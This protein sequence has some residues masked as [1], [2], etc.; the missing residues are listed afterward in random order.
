VTEKIVGIARRAMPWVSLAVGIAGAVL[1]DRGPERAAVVASAAVV[2]WV[3]VLL[4]IWLHR[5][6]QGESLPRPRLVRGVHFSSLVLTQSSIYLQLF[7]ALPFYGKAW[8]GTLG[9][10]AFLA[11]LIAAALASLWDPWTEWLLLRARGGLLYPAFASFAVLNAVLPGLGASNTQ[12]LWLAAAAAGLALPI[13]AVAD[14][15]HGRSPRRAIVL[16]AALGLPI[17]LLLALGGARWVPAAPM[18]LVRAEVGTRMSGRE[19]ADPTEHFDRRP[20]QLVCATAIWAPLGVREQL[21]HVWRHDGDVVDRI[22]LEIRGGREEGFRTWSIKRRFGADADGM[23]TC[24]VETATGQ[25]L[26]ERSVTV[27]ER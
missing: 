9:H 18:A 1:M 6:R 2:T 17:P 19:L 4:A 8:A 21:L 26:G 24:S 5:L 13:L 14:R 22:P 25:L 20:A 15:L 3:L 12:S 10:T 23:W 11:V 16:A 27:G 7:F